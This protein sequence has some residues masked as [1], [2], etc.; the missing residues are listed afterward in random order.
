MEDFPSP[1]DLSP[2]SKI[3][4]HHGSIPGLEARTE[5]IESLKIW[6]V[7]AF[8]DASCYTVLISPD[9]S[10]CYLRKLLWRLYSQSPERPFETSLEKEIPVEYAED[11]LNQ[12]GAIEMKPF[13]TSS[14][15]ILDAARIG[16]TFCRG[17]T[18]VELSWTGGF[19]GSFKE[20]EKWMG[21]TERA[22]EK[23]FSND[24]ET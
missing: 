12:L 21:S 19:E 22:F 15:L 14:D 1:S 8:L 10:E 24:P 18:S 6:C 13:H 4:A 16:L 5:F 23:Y 17:D 2:F 3:K 11:L 9:G 7:P 20:L